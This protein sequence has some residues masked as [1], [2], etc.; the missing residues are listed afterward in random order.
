M[1]SAVSVAGDDEKVVAVGEE[2]GGEDLEAGGG[3]AEEHHLVGFLGVAGEPEALDGVGEEAEARAAE[4]AHRRHV[5]VH[6]HEGD[7]QQG[8]VLLE[9]ADHALLALRHQHQALGADL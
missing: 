5:A 6:V 1:D 8:A 7:G 9:T 2:V 3:L 4:L